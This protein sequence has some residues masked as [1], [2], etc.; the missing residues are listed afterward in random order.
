MTAKCI[1][2]Q[3][4]AP[5][6]A[7]VISTH[8]FNLL[9][10]TLISYRNPPVASWQVLLLSII[11]VVQIWYWGFPTVSSHTG[12]ELCSGPQHTSPP[13]HLR[14]SSTE[15]KQWIGFN[16][17]T[18]RGQCSLSETGQEDSWFPT[19]H[20]CSNLCPS[21]H[22]YIFTGLLLIGVQFVLALVNDAVVHQQLTLRRADNYN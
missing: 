8:H 5:D 16:S 15:T 11:T 12:N 21:S 17:L 18:S 10:G 22:N 6:L 4:S 1:F 3:S 7:C 20:I 13:K 14:H 9:S 19:R 2:C